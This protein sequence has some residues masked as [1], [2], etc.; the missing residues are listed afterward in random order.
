MAQHN[1]FELLNIKYSQ[2]SQEMKD[3]IQRDVKFILDNG[4]NGTHIRFKEAVFIR[5]LNDNDYHDLRG[6]EWKKKDGLVF[7]TEQRVGD[8]VDEIEEGLEEMDAS[9]CYEILLALNEKSF[10]IE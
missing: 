4:H 2:L 5:M 6:I 1:S 8:N 9:A 7:H 3:A 10:N